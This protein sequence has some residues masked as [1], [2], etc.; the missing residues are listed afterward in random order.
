MRA[1]IAATHDE[2]KAISGDDVGEARGLGHA[3]MRGVRAEKHG[4]DEEAG[5]EA[6]LGFEFHDGPYLHGDESR[7]EKLLR[8]CVE[9]DVDLGLGGVGAGGEPPAAEFS[10]GCRVQQ[11]G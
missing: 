9:V 6:E 4:G 2:R 1:E 3:D 11:S 5:A 7:K 10:L 8:V